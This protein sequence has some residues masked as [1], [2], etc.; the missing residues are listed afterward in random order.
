MIQMWWDH[1]FLSGHYKI[2]S[3][4]SCQHIPVSHMLHFKAKSS[5][6]EEPS[7]GW[8]CMRMFLSASFFAVD[9]G[10]SRRAL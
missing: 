3:C 6:S 7:A 8:W 1:R 4:H 10:S 9:V 5:A 2:S